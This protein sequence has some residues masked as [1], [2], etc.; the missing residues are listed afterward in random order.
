MFDWS[1]RNRGLRGGQEAADRFFSFDGWC[2]APASVAAVCDGVFLAPFIHDRVV[3]K[4][5][6]HGSQTVDAMTSLVPR[7]KSSRPSALPLSDPR[8]ACPTRGRTP[9][10]CLRVGKR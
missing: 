8:A 6:F 4:H 5:P 10:S 1:V 7:C 2:L 3:E 9:P